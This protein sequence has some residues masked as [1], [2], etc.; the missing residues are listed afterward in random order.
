MGLRG[1]T[2]DTEHLYEE[3]VA[4]LLDSVQ[5]EA[6]V[7]QTFC[8]LSICLPPMIFFFWGG[9]GEKKGGL[10]DKKMTSQ[11]KTALLSENRSN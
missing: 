5:P 1:K 11:A 8:G 9:G 6:Q 3:P 7:M 2:V 4:A 10:Y